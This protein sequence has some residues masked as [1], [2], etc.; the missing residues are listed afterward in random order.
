MVQTPVLETDRLLLRPWR[1]ED[2][3]PYARILRDPEVMRH[4]GSGARHRLKRLGAGALGR[5]SRLEARRA[6]A[7]LRGHWERHGYGEWAVEDRAT[8]ALLGSIGLKH[9]DDWTAEAAKVEIGWLLAREAWGQGLATEG[10]RAGVAY[11]FGECGIDRLISIALPANP[12]SIGVM[13]RLGL[14]FQ[15]RTRWRGGEVVWYAI[16]RE[17]WKGGECATSS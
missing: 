15:G 3:A 10:A 8:G 1:A 16:D 14:D 11:A 17:A 5:V 13:E 4:M 2:V 9:Q 6:I 12:R 7:S